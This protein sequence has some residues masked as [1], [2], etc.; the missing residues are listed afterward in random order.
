MLQNKTGKDIFHRSVSRQNNVK[1]ES[2]D[3]RLAIAQTREKC[4]CQTSGNSK[5]S[6]KLL[7]PDVW[8]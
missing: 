5:I 1:E 6:E 4:Y 7:L 8:Q 2:S 3:R